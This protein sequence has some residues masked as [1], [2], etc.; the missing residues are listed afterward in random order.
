M[1][2]FIF[3]HSY[4]NI[5]KSEP[6]YKLNKVTRGIKSIKDILCTYTQTDLE[7]QR[8]KLISLLVF[9]EPNQ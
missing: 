5:M 6:L 9:A 4:Y 2:I 7:F 3:I 8:F 1:S